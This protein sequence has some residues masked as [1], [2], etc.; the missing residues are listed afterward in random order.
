MIVPDYIERSNRKTLSLTVLKDGNVIVKAPISMRDETI[1]K[2][3]EEKQDWIRSKL[4]IV[5]QTKTKFDDIIHYQKF[6]LYGNRYSLL[7]SDVKKIETNDAFQIVIPQKTEK[8]K[9]TKS[10]K[11]WYKK[12]AKQVLFDRLAFIESRVRLKSKAVK[13]NDSKGKWGSCNSM[14]TISLNWRVVMLPPRVIDYVLVHELCHLVEMN[15]S[16]KF[17]ELVNKFLP[18][19][20]ELKK[21]IK[22]YGILLNLF[23]NWWI[24]V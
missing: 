13:I 15:H 4:A 17:W 2:F 20:Q 9:I 5:N 23:V 10:L 24:F 11:S 14:G 7:L 8:E 1:N 22:E 21:E 18:N 19:V 6:L 3:V 12:I 16:K